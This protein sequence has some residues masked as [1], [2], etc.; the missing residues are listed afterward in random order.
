MMTVVHWEN[1][2]VLVN[3]VRFLV[4]R[5]EFTDTRRMGFDSS[6]S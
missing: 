6:Q 2:D 5:V 3:E 1:A 4:I